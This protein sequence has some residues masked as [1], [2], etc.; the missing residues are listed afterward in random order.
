M[1]DSGC[2]SHL[3]DIIYFIITKSHLLIQASLLQDSACYSFPVMRL[4]KKLDSLTWH[5]CL[6]ITF[7]QTS[8][9]ILAV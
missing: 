5:R 9:K 4:K 2:I 8:L 1:T 6:T 3:L 7:N